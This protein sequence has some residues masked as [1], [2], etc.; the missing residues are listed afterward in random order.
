MRFIPTSVGPS[1]SSKQLASPSRSRLGG[2]LQE[3]AIAARAR[4]GGGAGVSG[5]SYRLFRFASLTHVI[6]L[7]GSSVRHEL[8]QAGDIS[9]PALL[10]LGISLNGELLMTR[11]HTARGMRMLR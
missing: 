11:S 5:L 6:Q 10:P 4:C 8:V 7:A 3:F 2:A 9:A 1:L